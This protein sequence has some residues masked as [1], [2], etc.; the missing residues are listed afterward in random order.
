MLSTAAW[1]LAAPSA[2]TKVIME[3]SLE[4]F[5]A[6]W[7]RHFRHFHLE[8]KAYKYPRVAGYPRVLGLYERVGSGR[9]RS[10]SLIELVGSG[11]GSPFIGTGRVG[12]GF[13]LTRRQP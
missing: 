7:I 2:V 9:V 8:E 1:P 12:C 5:L 11:T 13:Y 6:A 3:P 4:A 10:S